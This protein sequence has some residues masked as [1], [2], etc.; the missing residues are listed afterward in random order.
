[1]LDVAIEPT[2]IRVGARFAVAFQRTLRLPDDGRTYPLPPGLG[3]L[4][5]HRARDHTS[6]VPAAWLEEDAA[7]IPMYQREALWLGFAAAPW[8]PNAVMVAVGGV[9][10]VSGEVDAAGLR[11]TPQNYVVC[12]EQLWLDG[13]N[14]GQGAVRQFVAMP[15]GLGYA[16]EASVAGRE[17]VGGI[18]ITVFEPKPG[19]F[20]EQEPPRVVRPEAPPRP[21]SAPRMGLGAGGVMRQKI[22]PDP[23]GVGTWDPNEAG[24]VVVHIV[25]SAHYA[26]IVGRAPPPTPI[27]VHSYAK[28]GLPWFDLYDEAKGDVAPAAPLSGARTVAERARELGV[29]SDDAAADLSASPLVRVSQDTGDRSP[30]GAGATPAPGPRD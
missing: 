20:P 1:M 21:M 3:A 11:A 29:E 26:E 6:R 12:P 27:D 28:H 14:T 7:F 8:K 22:Y 17:S 24:R 18:Q 23:Y 10:A 2:A 19:R 13:I 5:V 15:L 25:N 16:V 4:P 9:N 30:G